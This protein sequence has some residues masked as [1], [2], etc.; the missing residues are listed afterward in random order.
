MTIKEINPD[1]L[2]RDTSA[3]EMLGQTRGTLATWRSQGRGPAFVKLGRSVFYR[4]ADIH[5]FV[6][7]QRRDPAGAKNAAA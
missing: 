6:A 2:I 7:A 3:A 1:E 4:R 5:S